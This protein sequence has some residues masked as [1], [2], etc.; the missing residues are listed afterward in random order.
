MVLNNAQFSKRSGGAGPLCLLAAIALAFTAG[1]AV[2]PDYRRPA[3]PVSSAFKEA[4]GW[5]AASPSDAA[6]RG[7]WWAI[8]G[9]PVLN[10][11][12]SRVA[13]S[14]FSLQQT[15]ANYEEAREVARADRA[16]LLPTIS[17]VGSAQREKSPADNASGAASGT[18]GVPLFTPSS[19]PVSTFS[20]SV[21]ASWEP[22]FWGRIRRLTE[23]AVATAQADA[24][25]LA[26]ARLSTQASLAEDY[27]ELRVLDAKKQL[28][29]NAVEAYRRTLSITQNKYNVGV[30][31]RSDVLTAQTQ[32]DSTRT[33]A[34]DVGVQ[35]AEL[36][37]AIAVLM[38]KAP[39]EFSIASRPTLD[40][41]VPEIPLEMPSQLLE[42]RPD[43][44]SA[45]RGVASANANI[46]VQTAA[47]FP[48][49]TLSAAGGFEGSILDRLFTTPD[50]FWSL[51][52]QLTESLFDAGERH[53]A[54]L[55]ARAAYDASVAGYRQT[56][57]SAFQQV[58]D[59]LASLRILGQEVQIQDTAVSE[60]SDATRIAL[61][62]YKAGTI[63]FTTVTTA[64]VTELT[65]RETALAILQSRL[66]A[67]VA[68]VEALGG[69]WTASDLPNS[70]QVVARHSAD[71]A[72]VAAPQ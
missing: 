66:T 37:H 27:I 68:L 8:F 42:R 65:N 71:G 48:D 32:L 21:Q 14:N 52:S 18:G 40:I 30:A 13:T 31:A 63:D 53:D 62:E 39:S 9:D 46:G 12:E 57:L 70:R 6:P 24:A 28:L 25:D 36:E 60:A 41:A 10:D 50:R 59:D 17:A 29:D 20:A 72:S 38:G 69:G 54:V 5:K 15:A 1:C 34:L 7:P 4:Q 23:A 51:G 26:S 49:V 64:Q 19:E 58:E 67:G 56:V 33:Q 43:I 44:A 55:Q 11:L 2:G 16:T 47:Y 45:E 35:R 61:N 3:V 22:D